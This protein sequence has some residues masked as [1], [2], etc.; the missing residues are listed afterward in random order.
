MILFL[1]MFIINYM[2]VFNHNSYISLQQIT[3]KPLNKFFK[4]K[5]SSHLEKHISEPFQKMDNLFL[6]KYFKMILV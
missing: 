6:I 4:I 2:I 1:L 5:L 3:P